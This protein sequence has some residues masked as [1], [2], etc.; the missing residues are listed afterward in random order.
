MDIES[1]WACWSARLLG[2]PAVLSALM[3]AVAAL[4]PSASFAV[5]PYMQPP[6][7]L[8]A[9]A[10]K[11]ER[12]RRLAQLPLV[13]VEVEFGADQFSPA[14]IYVHRCYFEAVVRRS[15]QHADALPVGRRIRVHSDCKNEG[16]SHVVEIRPGVRVDLFSGPDERD[17]VPGSLLQV[18]LLPAY[19][20]L[21]GFNK[22]GPVT[23]LRALSDTPID[24]SAGQAYRASHM[25]D[26][27]LLDT[28]SPLPG[29]GD[30]PQFPLKDVVVTYKDSS[31]SG[32]LFR[33]SFQG[34]TWRVRME[35]LGEA[36]SKM[37]TIIDDAFAQT[38]AWIWDQTATYAIQMTDWRTRFGKVA[39][40]WKPLLEKQ[41]TDNIAGLACTEYVVLEREPAQICMTGDGVVLRRRYSDGHRT[42]AVTVEYKPVTREQVTIPKS[43]RAQTP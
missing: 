14:F 35:E 38:E 11:V 17:L 40:N 39:R 3:I 26:Y 43:Y 23:V 8:E 20:P 1:L 12:L 27:N 33:A 4:T 18:R 29:P 2:S 7:L 5:T 41:G 28:E 10:A 22:V 24:D 15:L 31:R 37:P 30:P 25:N 13:Q 21:D 16:Q 34:R 9:P 36:G 42:E 32:R 6:D 19:G